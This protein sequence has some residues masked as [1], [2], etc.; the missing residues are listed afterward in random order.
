[1]HCLFF[2]FFLIK[3]QLGLSCGFYFW[4][5][6]FSRIIWIWVLTLSH[7]LKGSV[8]GEMGQ[9]YISPPHWG[10]VEF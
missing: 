10:R 1:V 2:F 8:G 6:L 9:N 7:Y 4:G 5:F 3:M